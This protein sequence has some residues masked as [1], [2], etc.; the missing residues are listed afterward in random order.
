MMIFSFL[1]I[2]RRAGRCR[3]SY[4]VCIVYGIEM[5]SSSSAIHKEINRSMETLFKKNEIKK[6]EKSKN[7]FIIIAVRD[8][9]CDEQRNVGGSGG[10][11]N[12]K[13]ASRN[14]TKHKNEQ[15]VSPNWFWSGCCA[16]HVDCIAAYDFASRSLRFIVFPF[17]LWAK[18]FLYHFQLTRCSFFLRSC[19]QREGGRE[20]V[21]SFH[22][23]V[24]NFI[25]IN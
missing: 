12:K 2:R 3:R 5:L 19:N 23:S 24:K 13:C 25:F 7:A 9:R 20:R 1:T 21:N 8:Y 4:I 14:K 10:E 16:E 6:A 18:H 15:T 11:G 22:N 17:L